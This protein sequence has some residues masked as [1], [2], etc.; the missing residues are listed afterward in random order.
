M[1]L[2]M[3]LIACTCVSAAVDCLR[4]ADHI[5]INQKFIDGGPGTKVFL[6][7]DSKHRISGT[8]IFTAADQELATSGYPT[9]SR[10][11][12]ISIENDRVATAIR[13]DCRRCARISIK[14]VI[15]DGGRDRLGRIQD[16]NNAPG[17]IVIGGNEG[18]TISHCWVKEP[19][20]FTAIHVREGDKLQCRL[21]VIEGNEIGPVGEEYNPIE[22]GP[23]PE[24][25]PLGRPLADG[26]SIACQDSTVRDNNIYDC[27]DAGIVVYCSPGTRVTGNTVSTRRQSAM[28]GIFMVDAAP[29][30]GDYS[31]VVVQDNTFD[32]A[33]RA[34]RVGIGLGLSILGDDIETILSGGKVIHNHLKGRYM[35]YGI[36]AAGL[37]NWEITENWS[38]ATHSGTM[39]A[40][41]FDDVVNP[42]PVPFLY[43]G[44]TVTKSKVQPGFVDSDFAYGELTCPPLADVQSCALTETRT[45]TRTTSTS[46][47]LTRR[48]FLF[49][50]RKTSLTA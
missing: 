38:D 43:H 20:G 49:R 25:S 17:L 19:R 4:N 46:P 33:G 13:G 10:R 24:S 36:A 11:A 12:T 42:D 32:A 31:G 35:G 50:P 44:K 29:F 5:T 37:S 15:V 14:N 40:R 2:F 9:G 22:D 28:G 21:A 34:M 45:R 48:R 6:C 16:H 41:C 23:D 30:E 1:W 27:T 18:Q 3:L 26:I 47:G 39:S 8:I 7:P